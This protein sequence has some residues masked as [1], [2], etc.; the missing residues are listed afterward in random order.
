M[1]PQTSVEICGIKFKNP[2]IA[3]SGTFSFG[4]EHAEYTDLNRIGGIAVKGLTLEPKKGNP[5]PRIAETP[6]GILNSV[7]LQNPGIDFFIKHQLPRLTEYDTRIIININGNTEDEYCML[8]EKLRDKPVDLLELNIS[9]PN[10]REGGM[11][12]GTDPRMVYNVTK[13]VK[14]H[15][16]QPV[17]VKLTP[18]VTDIK[19]IAI[20]VEEGGGNGISLINTVLGMAIDARSRK[21]I[22][23]NVVGG[24]SGPAIKPIALRMVW[25]VSNV[26]TIP[27]VGMGGIVTGEDAV[28]FLLAGA[29]A[30]GVGTANLITPDACIDIV[31][32]LEEYMINNGIK[33]INELIGGLIV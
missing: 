6:S 27:I 26:V 7:G 21:P 33:D 23:A 11:A 14:A 15:A 30:V 22:L 32:Q 13:S 25:E 28:E 20:A 17:L 24:L 31:H 19:E 10:V 12:F 5:P 9:C 3:A 16:G 8:A 29:T 2:V 4:I 18:N 1:R